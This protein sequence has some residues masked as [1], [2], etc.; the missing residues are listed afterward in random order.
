MVAPCPLS[1][2]ARLTPRYLIELLVQSAYS[3]IA[4]QYVQ[5]I[6]RRMSAFRALTAKCALQLREGM[7]VK[8]Q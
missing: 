4:K 2:K 7:N 6:D 3:F 1:L 8:I 5:F